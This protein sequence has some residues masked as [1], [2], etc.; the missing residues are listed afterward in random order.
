M[1]WDQETAKRYEAW[2]QTPSGLF[3]L[4]REI[5]LL[6]QMTADWPRRGQRLV[7]IGCGTGIFLESL[8]RAGF[9][10]TGLDA[11]PAMLE[12]ARERLGQVADLHLGR[13]EH[14]P[15]PDKEFDFAVL[16]TVLEFCPEPV[17][18]LREA[19]RVTRKALLVGFLNRFSLYWLTTVWQRD[20]RRDHA[21]ER[22]HWFTPWAMAR[23]IR[24]A[25][26]PRQGA[27]Y[28]VLAGPKVTWREGWPGRA[29]NDPLCSVPL[30]AYCVRTISLTGAPRM[31]S[32]P[33][34]KAK[35]CVG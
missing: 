15:F 25:L 10:V 35:T 26:G 16:L 13:A 12:V 27:Q 3:A 2:F 21:L 22:T 9:D 8:H 7:E 4:K 18:A 23:L 19:A 31:T 1:K 29:L 32:L 6:E 11:S 20:R 33:A 17:L 24:E 28:S 34:F 14:L 5:R 30:G